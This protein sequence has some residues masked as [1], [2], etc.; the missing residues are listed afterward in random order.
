MNPIQATAPGKIILLGD[1][2]V[3]YGRPAIAVPVTHL[4][5]TAILQPSEAGCHIIASDVGQAYPLT[6][7][8]ANDPLAAIIFAT[9]EH[10]GQ[11]TPPNLQLHI[12]STI[13]LGRGLGSGAAVSTAIVR[14]LAQF[15]NHVLP[16]A[17]VSALVYEVEKVHHGTPSGI[18]NTVIAFAQPVYFRRGRPIQRLTV[19]QPFSLLIADTGIVSPT[20]RPVGAVRRRWQANPELYE[21]YFDEIGVIVDQAR[22]ILEQGYV[23]LAALGQ[24]MNENQELLA[25]IG[26]SSPELERLV[27]AARQRGALG[28]KLSGGGWGGNMIA[29]VTPDKVEAMS[30]AL[31][32]AGAVAVMATT[33]S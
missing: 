21:G 1:H 33:V 8:P 23:G 15:Y 29:L 10:L 5:A 3:V 2:A 31:T 30:Q 28:A 11:T 24:L 19:Q 14:A 16:P 27:M 6:E 26:V 4:Q 9:L 32:D 17:E 13:P 22:V 18:D 25:T 12:T 7:A 20:H